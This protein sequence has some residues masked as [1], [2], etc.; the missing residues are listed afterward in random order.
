[1]LDLKFLELK[2]YSKTF[3]CLEFTHFG[4]VSVHQLLLIT[5][6]N[7]RRKL[8]KLFKY[9]FSRFYLYRVYLPT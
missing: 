9:T 1:M 6:Q 3:K 8:K 5:N 4:Q 2:H 7:N